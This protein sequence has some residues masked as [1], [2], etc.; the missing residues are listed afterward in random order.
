MLCSTCIIHLI[1]KKKKHSET[2]VTKQRDPKQQQAA[3]QQQIHNVTLDTVFVCRSCL[4]FCAHN[5][6]WVRH[7]QSPWYASDRHTHTHTQS[8]FHYLHT[9][10][11]YN[12]F[13]I[14]FFKTWNLSSGMWKPYMNVLANEKIWKQKWTK[15]TRSRPYNNRSRCVIISKYIILYRWLRKKD[16]KSLL[17]SSQI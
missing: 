16:I 12:F 5:E 9:K 4:Q 2:I 14:S 8:G 13:S 6:L 7:T 11:Y 15:T 1:Q 17:I 3:H 10:N